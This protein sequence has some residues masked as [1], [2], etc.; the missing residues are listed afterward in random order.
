[1]AHT[2]VV[3][4]LNAERDLELLFE[5]IAIDGGIDR[6]EAVLR[7]IDATTHRLADFPGIGKVHPDL[8]GAP[9][10]FSVWPW[11]VIYERLPDGKGIYVLRVMDG[12]RDVPRHMTSR[13]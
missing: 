4:S 9:R 8:D 10:A 11:L 1:M 12:R 5:Y 13:P 2:R 3:R 7:R 6:A